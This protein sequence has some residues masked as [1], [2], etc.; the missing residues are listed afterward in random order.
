MIGSI[1]EKILSLDNTKSFYEQEV[2]SEIIRDIYNLDVVYVGLSQSDYNEG[3]ETSTPGIFT[4]D[5]VPAIYIFS[6]EEYAKLW[7]AH[8]RLNIAKIERKEG[9]DV[10]YASL[11]QIARARG[12]ERVFIDE[13]QK[14]LCF[15]IKDLF[16]I[17]YAEPKVEFLP[18][19]EENRTHW[20]P[21]SEA[22]FRFNRHRVH[23]KP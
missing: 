18:T 6:K 21:K 16:D 3:D 12:V 19:E 11:Y 2:Y 20:V 5:G 13:G 14:F 22:D 1:Q 10:P 7:A 17:A 8:Y 9:I 23:I 4:K 15:Y